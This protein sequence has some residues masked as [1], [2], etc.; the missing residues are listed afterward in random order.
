[1]CIKNVA[2]NNIKDSMNAIAAG[3]VTG[4]GTLGGTS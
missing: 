2:V 3:S 1:M 4:M